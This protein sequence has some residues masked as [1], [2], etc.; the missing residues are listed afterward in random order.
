MKIIEATT[1]SPDVLLF[2]FRGLNL[3]RKM[4][5]S[6]LRKSSIAG[7][8][9]PRVVCSLPLVEEVPKF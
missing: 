8:C 4:A 3:G 9:G 7:R 1:Y 6:R 2:V 5:N